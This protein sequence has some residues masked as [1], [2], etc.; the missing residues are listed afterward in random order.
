MEARRAGDMDAA[1]LRR[2]AHQIVAPPAATQG[3]LQ[4]VGSCIELP[5]H[6]WGFWLT[7]ST[8]F[9]RA[10][11]AVM[12]LIEA[13]EALASDPDLAKSVDD[14]LWIRV[15]CT[16]RYNNVDHLPKHGRCAWRSRAAAPPT[17]WPACRARLSATVRVLYADWCTPGL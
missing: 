11:L 14:Y 12:G 3:R 16:F 2:L 15:R 5:P 4:P 6:V 1:T 9:R 7:L 13:D 17:C 10:C 8:Q